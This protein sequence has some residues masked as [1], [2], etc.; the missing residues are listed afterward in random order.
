MATTEPRGKGRCMPPRKIDWRG[1]P[2][3]LRHDPELMHWRMDG[4]EERVDQIETRSTWPLIESVSWPQIL[5][6][7]G[8]LALG[9]TGHADWALRLLG[10]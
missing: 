10:R 1:L 9:L 5:T 6:L 7:L 2:P 8:L 3:S 4:L